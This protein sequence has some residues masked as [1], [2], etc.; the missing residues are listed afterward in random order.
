LNRCRKLSRTLIRI[1]VGH[2]AE[3][4]GGDIYLNGLRGSLPSHPG[5]MLA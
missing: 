4:P 3:T 2:H 1:A 5:E